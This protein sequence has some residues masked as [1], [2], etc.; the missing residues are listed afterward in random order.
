MLKFYSCK[1]LVKLQNCN[2]S[3]TILV[4]SLFPLMFL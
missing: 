2:V 1:F 3:S 4:K